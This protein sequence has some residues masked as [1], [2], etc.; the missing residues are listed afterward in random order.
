MIDRKAE[1]NRKIK[2]KTSSTKKER[3]IEGWGERDGERGMGREGWGERDGERGMGREGW[4]ERMGERRNKSTTTTTNKQTHESKKHIKG[5]RIV[6]HFIS[7]TT[8]TL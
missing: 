1:K 3:Q 4:G 2:R 8:N 6:K 5:F 7:D